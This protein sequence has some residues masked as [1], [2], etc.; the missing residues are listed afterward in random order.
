[1]I[2]LSAIKARAAA[3]AASAAKPANAAIPANPANPHE[4]TTPEDGALAALATVATLARVA[5][6]ADTRVTCTTCRHHLPLQFRCGNHRA[7]LLWSGEV[8]PALA[9]LPQN[10]PG[11]RAKR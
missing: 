2:D 5:T 7:A 9:V 10:C 6:L 3:R 11:W 4:R 8:A 1:M